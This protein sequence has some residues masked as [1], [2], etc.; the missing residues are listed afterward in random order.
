MQR[1]FVWK[2]QPKVEAQVGRGVCRQTAGED[3]HGLTP[4][5]ARKFL[6]EMRLPTMVQ[7]NFALWQLRGVAIFHQ[8]LNWLQM[9]IEQPGLV[10]RVKLFCNEWSL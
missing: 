3:S 7:N 2:Y 10:L 8:E 9:N 6:F 5:H 4:H 1:Q